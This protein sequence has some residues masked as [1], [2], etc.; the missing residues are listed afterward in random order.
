MVL[1]NQTHSAS[2]N[3][4]LL[5]GAGFGLK[6]ELIAPLQAAFESD[7]IEHVSFLEIAPENWIEAGGKQAVQ[8][9]WLAERFPLTCHGLSLSLGGPDPL[10]TFFLQQVK[11]FLN[12]HKIVLYTEHLSYCSDLNLGKPSYMHDLLPIPFT[13]EAVFYVANRIKQV[14]DTLER[15]IAIENTSYYAEAPIS[16]MDELTFLNAVLSEADCDLHLDI[17][18]IYVNSVNFGFDPHVFLRGVPGERIVYAHIAGHDREADNLIIDTHAQDV[19]PEVWALLE[20][21]YQLYGV[22]P[23]LLERDTNI[24]ALPI[25]M[26]EINQI[27]VL[28]RQYQAIQP[29]LASA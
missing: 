20:E 25:L 27:A 28:Q 6:R 5:K 9:A 17:N 23:T 2:K 3:V 26:H 15:R 8:I 22:F 16:S 24:P 4:A 14:Q 18:N 7:L 10:N 29:L 21:A 12:Q 11:S 13:E 19:V 1:T